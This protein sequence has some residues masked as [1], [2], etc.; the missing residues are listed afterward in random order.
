MQICD[1]FLY[2]QCFLIHVRPCIPFIA[3]YP[4]CGY[5]LFIVQLDIWAISF[6]FK[7]FFFFNIV[8]TYF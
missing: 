6:F 4:L 8:F 7:S 3:E 5:I 2:F 1:W